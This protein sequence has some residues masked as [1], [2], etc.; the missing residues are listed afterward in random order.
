MASNMASNSAKESR[1]LMIF[2]WVDCQPEQVGVLLLE[3][4]KNCPLQPFDHSE[5][6]VQPGERRL[7]C[8]LTDYITGIS[9][10]FPKFLSDFKLT[11]EIS[12]N[13]SY[14]LNYICF[15]FEILC[16]FVSSKLTVI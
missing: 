9:Y 2:N 14:K 1:N 7:A 15:D 16:M 12:Y 8:Q 6:S 11:T 13:W 10:T 3:E 4:E 5:I